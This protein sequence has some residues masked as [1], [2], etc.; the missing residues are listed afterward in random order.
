M[1]IYEVS[2]A[3]L[4]ALNKDVSEDLILDFDE[5]D[6]KFYVDPEKVIAKRPDDAG[7]ADK[8][9]AIGTPTD[10]YTVGAEP[11]TALLKLL[12]ANGTITDADAK[13]VNP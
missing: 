4:D 5:F 12:V 2:K 13:A 11:L 1:T 7:V 10:L 8:L 3:D 6:G 9:E